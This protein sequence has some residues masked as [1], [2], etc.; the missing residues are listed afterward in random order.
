MNWK[1]LNQPLGISDAS[2]GYA[3]RKKPWILS[4]ALA[5]GSLVSSLFGASA[6]RRAAEQARR[7]QEAEKAAKEAERL[8]NK[9]QSWLDTKSGQNTMRVLQSQAQKFVNQQRGA[10]AVGNGTDAAVA[11]EKE[12]QNQKQADIIAQAEANH[13]QQANINDAQYR[14]EIDRLNS[15]IRQSKMMQAEAS[16]Q[17]A[18]AVSDALMKGAAMAAGPKLT[19]G[20]NG[21]KES[22]TGT[23]S[24]GGGGVTPSDAIVHINDPAFLEHQGSSAQPFS[25]RDYSNKLASR[26]FGYGKDFRT[27]SKTAI[28]TFKY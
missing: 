7:E 24:P 23:G 13:E 9:N 11:M 18:G 10:Q 5:A 6:S 2:G 8:R 1:I 17:V 12:L 21:G 15:G 26:L 22:N 25:M 28:G 19:G 16:S 4:A 20:S 27:A 14:Q 3:P